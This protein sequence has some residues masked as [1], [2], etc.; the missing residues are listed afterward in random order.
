MISI[1]KEKSQ[2]IRRRI[3]SQIMINQITTAIVFLE[4]QWVLTDPDLIE[5]FS[6][7]QQSNLIA[8]NKLI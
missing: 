1:D 2:N 5:N 7:V 4:V 6:K 3:E 8:K